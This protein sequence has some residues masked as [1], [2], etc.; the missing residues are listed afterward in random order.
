MNFYQ[1]DLRTAYG[2]A[3]VDLGK[4][5]QNVIV[6]DADLKTST[7]TSLFADAYPKRFIQC[8]IAEANMMGIAAGL[9]HLG[10]VAFPTTFAAFVIRKALDSFYMHACLHNSSVKAVGAYSGLTAGECG[11]SH[12]EC[13]DIA[14]LRTMPNLK[15]AVPGDNCE[16]RAVMKKM[17][18]EPGPAYLR[19]AKANMPVLFDSTYQFEWGKGDLL[20]EGSDITLV[21]TGMMTGIALKAA[22]L[23]STDG[24]S[25]QVVHM[26]SVHPL[27]EELLLKCARRTGCLLTI[28][29]AKIS[30]G[31]GSAIQELMCREYPVR[32]CCI[33]VRDEVVGSDTLSSLLVHQGLTPEA[34]YLQA[35]LLIQKKGD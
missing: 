26:A 34:M 14:I 3:L 31:F 11:P 2:K 5:R 10:Y 1:E 7:M 16:L 25:A 30:G 17:A 22:E 32:V 6:L 21:S 27:D 19:L 20:R 4:E 12:N 28:E 24:Y 9:A 33:G 8:G 29:N 18:A 35:K 23:L 13:E 15:I